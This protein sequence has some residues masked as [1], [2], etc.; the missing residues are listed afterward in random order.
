MYTYGVQVVCIPTVYSTTTVYAYVHVLYTYGVVG[1]S[2]TCVVRY[3]QCIACVHTTY[4]YLRCTKVHAL[5]HAWCA[6]TTA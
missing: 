3:M 6:S 5:R 1:V 4:V 2:T